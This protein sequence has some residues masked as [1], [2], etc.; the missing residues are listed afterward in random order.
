M[1]EVVGIELYWK[2]IA[3]MVGLVCE[4]VTGFLHEVVLLDVG[5]SQTLLIVALRC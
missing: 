4:V 3:K 2:L 5:K 1:C